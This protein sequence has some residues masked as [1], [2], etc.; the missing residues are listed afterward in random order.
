MRLKPLEWL[1]VAAATVGVTLL[2]ANELSN[3][4][5]KPL[6]VALALLAAAVWAIGTQRLRMSQMPASTLTIS[7]WMIALAA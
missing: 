3:L 7:F 2:L 5:G 1:G 4:S 6:G